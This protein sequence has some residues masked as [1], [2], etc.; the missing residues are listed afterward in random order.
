MKT[1]C[2]DGQGFDI[3]AVMDLIAKVKRYGGRLEKF[4]SDLVD[5]CEPWCFVPYTTDLHTT[6]MFHCSDFV[7]AQEKEALRCLEQL[8]KLPMT[9]S[10]LEVSCSFYWQEVLVTGMSTFCGYSVAISPC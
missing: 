4:P 2:S 1:F 10:I 9:I 5:V 7:F 3:N 8:E 6:S